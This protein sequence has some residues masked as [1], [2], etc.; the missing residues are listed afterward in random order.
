MTLSKFNPELQI[1]G[2]FAQSGLSVKG[3]TDFALNFKP[4]ESLTANRTL[5]FKVNDADRTI[6]LSG[7][8]TLAAAFSTSGANAITLTGASGGSSITLPAT[9]TVATL[10]GTETLTN[11]K[12]NTSNCSFADNSDLTKL[13]KFSASGNGTGRSLTLASAISSSDKTITFPNITGTVSLLNGTAAF[14]TNQTFSNGL[15]TYGLGLN[16]QVGGITFGDVQNNSSGT[17]IELDLSSAANDYTAVELINSGLVSVKSINSGNATFLILRNRTGNPITLKNNGTPSAGNTIITGYGADITIPDTGSIALNFDFNSSP[18]SWYPILSYQ[19]PVITG[20]IF[21]SANNTL[22]INGTTIVDTESAPGDTVSIGNAFSAWYLY[23]SGD[24]QGISFGGTGNHPIQAVD[25]T[26]QIGSFESIGDIQIANGKTIAAAVG[27]NEALIGAYGVGGFSSLISLQSSS[28]VDAVFN[29]EP[30]DS[31]T[32]TINNIDI[33]STTPAQGFFTNLFSNTKLGY[34]TSGGQ[35]T[36]GTSITTD[37]TLNT[38]CGRVT[39]VSGTINANSAI[40]FAVYT[41]KLEE[42]DTIV[43][44]G[45]ASSNDSSYSYRISKDY[46]GYTNYF[47]I[48]IRNNSG[49]NLTATHKIDFSIIKSVNA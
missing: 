31:S 29:I 26:L 27:D 24:D 9:G 4:N 1:E 30:M 40:R 18:Q 49:S 42:F 20:S 11:K 35:V 47:N 48:T 5:N 43:C 22:K 2:A 45:I 7:N 33:G 36:Q 23:V 12:L 10:A 17:D 14:T 25:G 28:A 19:I 44:N 8:L 41:D 46:N 13:I 15:T 3:A 39:T 37:V 6:D 16:A 32:A 21:D 38:I 34:N